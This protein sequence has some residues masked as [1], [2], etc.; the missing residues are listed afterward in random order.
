MATSP[1]LDWLIPLLWKGS[2][3]SHALAPG[4][5][6]EI[7][8]ISTHHINSITFNQDLLH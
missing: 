3:G 4:S 7:R 6:K 1:S 5:C 8:E 2:E